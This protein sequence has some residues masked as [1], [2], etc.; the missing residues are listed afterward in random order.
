MPRMLVP[1]AYAAH[2]DA[3]LAPADA[4]ARRDDLENMPKWWTLQLVALL[5]QRSGKPPDASADELFRRC[6]VSW[7]PSI[8]R[9]EYL[10]AVP[11]DRA[12]ALALWLLSKERQ[13]TWVAAVVDSAKVKA[14]VKSLSG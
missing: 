14:M 3:L 6:Y 8:W 5:A 7:T 1:T 4:L 2:G 9:I 13:A 10:R 12:E 11:P